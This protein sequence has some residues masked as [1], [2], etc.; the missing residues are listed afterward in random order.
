M[1]PEVKQWQQNLAWRGCEKYKGNEL[2]GQAEK[3]R[4]QRWRFHKIIKNERSMRKELL[5]YKQHYTIKETKYKFW[6]IG[7]VT[8]TTGPCYIF[9]LL[10]NKLRIIPAMQMK[11]NYD[12]TN[13]GLHFT[14]LFDWWKAQWYGSGAEK[15]SLQAHGRMCNGSSS[16]GLIS[17]V[18]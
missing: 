16:A 3:T 7:I 11:C 5:I 14:H 17:S 13:S 4:W 8:E 9:A 15:T 12:I 18:W 2:E 1:T 6:N 10:F